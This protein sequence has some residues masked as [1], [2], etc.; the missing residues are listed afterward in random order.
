VAEIAASQPPD[1]SARLSFAKLDVAGTIERA[2]REQRRAHDLCRVA[3]EILQESAESQQRLTAV[4]W[5][6][7]AGK[8]KKAQPLHRQV[9]IDIIA[10]ES[11]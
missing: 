2:R 7:S 11:G 10:R 4:R 6:K 9:D 3:H 1:L 5:L 8:A